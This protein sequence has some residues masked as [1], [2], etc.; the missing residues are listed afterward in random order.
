[1]S[2]DGQTPSKSTK[3]S[4]RE[5]S[6]RNDASAPG[7]ER[8]FPHPEDVV[9]VKSTDTSPNKKTP[10]K[11]TT[12]PG[13]AAGK[14]AGSPAPSTPKKRKVYASGGKSPNKSPLLLLEESLSCVP[15]KGSKT[16]S[17]KKTVTKRQAAE[18]EE[19][20]QTAALEDMVRV[21]KGAVVGVKSSKTE[22]TSRER[23]LSVIGDRMERMECVVSKLK[24]FIYH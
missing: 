21:V 15:K 19:E 5:S 2:D 18:R 23:W 14:T 24:Y 13:K 8:G 22:P 10:T 4:K 11:K 6:S 3:R 20:R 12:T 7:F 9:S 1:M 16:K 17:S